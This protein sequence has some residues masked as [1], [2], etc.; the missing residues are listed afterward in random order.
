MTAVPSVTR[1]FKRPKKGVLIERRLRTGVALFP[2]AEELDW[3]GP[4][5]VLES[6]LGTLS[7]RAV[8]SARTASQV[9]NAHDSH[10]SNLAPADVRPWIGHSPQ[11]RTGDG[12]HGRGRRPRKGL[13]GLWELVRAHGAS[14][15]QA[16]AAHPSRWLTGKQ[17]A[18][19]H[20]RNGPWPPGVPSSPPPSDLG[21]EWGSHLL[22]ARFHGD[23]A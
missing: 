6:E 3:A 10:Y 4:W 14:M 21:E 18:G 20:S 9:E 22:Q 12:Y 23:S 7:E 2:D 1:K 11:R 19:W 5:E 13:D 17:L 16:F 15:F 8:V